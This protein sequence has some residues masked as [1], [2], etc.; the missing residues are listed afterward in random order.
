[1]TPDLIEGPPAEKAEGAPLPGDAEDPTATLLANS[2]VEGN[3]TP[4]PGNSR[5]MGGLLRV[6]ETGA[7]ANTNGERELSSWVVYVVRESA[8]QLHRSSRLQRFF[9][10]Q[11]PMK[12]ATLKCMALIAAKRYTL[13]Y[14]SCSAVPKPFFFF[15]LV[16]H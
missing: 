13:I 12:A 15:F 16:S 2:G 11:G 14:P 9:P 1:M 10:T 8:A 5:K 6:K 7:A 3:S 4:S